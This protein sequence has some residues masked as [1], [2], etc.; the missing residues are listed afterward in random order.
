MTS[1]KNEHLIWGYA[2]RT[3]GKGKVIIIG[4]TDHSIAYLQRA[5]G[6][7]LPITA[8]MKAGFMGVTNILVYRARD[9]AA[10]KALLEQAGVDIVSEV[11]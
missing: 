6:N 9:K 1:V 2:D 8:P 11:N 5:E 7:A 10:L 3:D 4:L